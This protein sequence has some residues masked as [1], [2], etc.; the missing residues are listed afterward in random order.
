MERNA[1][2]PPGKRVPGEVIESKYR[3]L[4][5]PSLEEGFDKII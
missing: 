4:E 1:T 3:E 5:M 2:R